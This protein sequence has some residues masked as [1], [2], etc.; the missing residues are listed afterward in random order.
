MACCFFD[1]AS[2][3]PRFGPAPPD[4]PG[5]LVHHLQGVPTIRGRRGA[6]WTCGPT[7]FGLEAHG[8]FFVASHRVCCSAV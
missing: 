6:G 2:D 8:R 1:V 4:P 5:A 3:A 7:G